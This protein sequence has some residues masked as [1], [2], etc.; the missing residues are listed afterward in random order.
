MASPLHS[1]QRSQLLR[2]MGKSC[3]RKPSAEYSPVILVIIYA[4]SATVLSIMLHMYLERSN[5]KT[6]D[7]QCSSKS[8]K[9]CSRADGCWQIRWKHEI[10]RWWGGETN[11][12][13]STLT[14]Q[15]G[16]ARII[17]LLANLLKQC[18]VADFRSI[19]SFKSSLFEFEVTRAKQ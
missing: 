7:T 19:T 17:Y 6:P 16:L 2:Q 12:N 1:P 9:R 11:E 18:R 14:S 13:Q 15:R 3:C 4:T 5:T 10:Q 8:D